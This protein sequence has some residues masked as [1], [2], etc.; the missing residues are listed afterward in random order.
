MA[1]STN[2]LLF[3]CPMVFLAGFIDSIA[4]GGGLISLTSY[5]AC[6]I[7]GTLA[8]GTNKFS[9][10]TG[11]TI[12]SVNY[13]R[14][15]NY[16]LRTLVSASIAAIAGSW[17]G[18]S[19]TMLIDPKVFSTIVLVITPIA[20]VMVVVDKKHEEREKELTT[21]AAILIG[22]AIGLVVGFYDGFYGPATGMF[23]QMS[24][25]LFAGLDAKKAAGNARIANW[26]SNFSALANFIRTDNVIYTI[27]IP[28]AACS[29]VGNWLG[30]R[31]AIKK[32][33]RIV[34]PIML[35]VISL[36][37]FKILLDLL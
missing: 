20:A 7:P 28:C 22:I 32:D 33:T 10:F 18:S 9:S 35:C 11:S 1:I 12:A 26:A 6:G 23:L 15:K 8:L 21:T 37:F 4:G 2:V 3:L 16:E 13:M 14:T 30:S 17:A 29:M 5:M 31:L 19:C 25:I 36:L 34:R 24:F 27:A